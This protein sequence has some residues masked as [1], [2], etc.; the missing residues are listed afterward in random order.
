MF[1]T[2]YFYLITKATFTFFKLEFLIFKDAL[3]VSH[4]SRGNASKR[5]VYP[6][7][8]MVE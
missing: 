2:F 8:V 5:P 1:Q 4:I 7:V 6:S 3:S